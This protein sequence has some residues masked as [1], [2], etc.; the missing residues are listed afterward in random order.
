MLPE[1]AN[2]E[3]KSPA[4]AFD[5]DRPARHTVRPAGVDAR[6]LGRHMRRLLAGIALIVSSLAQ[7]MPTGYAVGATVIP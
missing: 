2:S 3:A 1:D 4:L 5:P 6:P 7:C